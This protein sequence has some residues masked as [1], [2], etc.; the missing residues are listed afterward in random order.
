M[1]CAETDFSQEEIQRSPRENVHNSH[2][3]RRHRIRIINLENN[4]PEDF[5][6]SIRNQI[7]EEESKIV[8][9]LKRSSFTRA[10]YRRRHQKN[11]CIHS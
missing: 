3:L 2:T 4:L 1:G 6:Q 8:R 7:R 11:T 5:I 9:N 10:I